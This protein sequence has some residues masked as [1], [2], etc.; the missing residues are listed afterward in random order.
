[1][2][3]ASNFNLF[4][5]DRRLDGPIPKQRRTKK[6]VFQTPSFLITKSLII[7]NPVFSDHLYDQK[8]GLISKF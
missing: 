1:M 4:A 6:L 3:A 7:A 5:L 8:R 2:R